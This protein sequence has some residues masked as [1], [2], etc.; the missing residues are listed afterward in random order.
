MSFLNALYMQE[1]LNIFKFLLSLK[2]KVQNLLY[3]LDKLM[4]TLFIFRSLKSLEWNLVNKQQ[5]LMVKKLDWMSYMNFH[6]LEV[7][8][9]SML[10]TAKYQSMVIL[11]P[12]E[13]LIIKQLVK[14]QNGVIP[15]TQK[16]LLNIVMM[17]IDYIHYILI[18]ILNQNILYY[19]YKLDTP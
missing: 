7:E 10:K 13:S 5:K 11:T 16:K 14:F 17:V 15:N 3:L 8:E 12:M 9:F 6:V 18:K 19:N 4:L 2:Y 1:A